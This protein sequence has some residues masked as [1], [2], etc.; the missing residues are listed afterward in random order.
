MLAPSSKAEKPRIV[1]EALKIAA[2]RIIAGGGDETINAVASAVVKYGGKKPDSIL[3]VWPFGTANDFARGL[4]LPSVDLAEC[5]RIA[6]T[7]GRQL[8]DVGALNGRYFI[9]VA[10]MGFGP[11]VTAST[12]IQLKKALESCAG[13]LMNSKIR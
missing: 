10:S 1:R 12:P 13:T 5:L 4:K 9:N 2:Q 8:I 11:E 7:R 6:C 3:G